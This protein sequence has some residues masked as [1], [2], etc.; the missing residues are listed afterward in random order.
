MAA[1]NR[2]ERAFCKRTVER[3][4]DVGLARLLALVAEDNED[5]A[6]LLAS[7][8]RDP[9]AVSFGLTADR[10]HQAERRARI[11]P[12]R[13]AVR[14][15]LGDDGGRGQSR[16]TPSDF[17]D[18]AEDARIT[19]LAA[20]CSPFT[21]ALVGLLVALVHKINARAERRAEK[22]LTAYCATARTTP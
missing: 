3:L 13:G 12:S 9:G 8:K 20:L 15:L 6:A 10:D 22:K 7:L 17:R 11:R 14:G 2:W 21:D 4:D 18:T 1:S 16:R 5:G 19:L